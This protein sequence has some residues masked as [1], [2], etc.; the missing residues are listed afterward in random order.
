M[1][2]TASCIYR[3]IL[4][5]V[6]CLTILVSIVTFNDQV[7][8]AFQTSTMLYTSLGLF[9]GSFIL[10]LGSKIWEARKQYKILFTIIFGLSTILFLANGCAYAEPGSVFI[11]LILSIVLFTTLLIMASKNPLTMSK[12]KK[13]GIPLFTS[14]FGLIIILIANIFLQ[15][16]W[17]DLIISLC[18]VLLFSFMV[19]YDVS[20]YTKHCSGSDCCIDGTV[21]LWLD[22]ANIFLGL[23]GLK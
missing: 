18:I 3:N 19:V 13:W 21:N 5:F 7:K 12:I 20:F 9:I 17:L 14:L 16:Q 10:L 1:K 15:I 2:E 4:V 6:V 22:F 11:A 23:L 8:D